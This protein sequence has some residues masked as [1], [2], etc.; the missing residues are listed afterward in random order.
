MPRRPFRLLVITRDLLPLRRHYEDVFAALGEAGVAISIR[1]TH[2]AGLG[3]SEYER[4]LRARN[5]SA[6]V[7]Q[8]PR[9][10]GDHYRLAVNLRQLSNLLRFSH[11]DFR[12]RDWVRDIKWDR[13]A[14]GPLRWA[15]RIER[16]GSRAALATIALAERVDRLLPASEDAA[17]LIEAESPDAVAAV[18]VMRAP[19]F[20]E[21][22]KA[23]RAAGVPTAIWV[24]SWDNLSSKGLLHFVPDR[25]FVWNATQLG[26]LERYHGIPADRVSI[27]GAQSFDHWFNGDRP[28]GREDFC[29]RHGLDPDRPI[30]LY[31]VSS[32]G[33]EPS[34]ATFLLRWLEAIRASDD[35]QLA[36]ASVIVRPH[37]T[38]PDPWLEATTDD[39]R[40]V[41]SPNASADPDGSPGFRRRFREELHHSSVA[42]GINTS[43]LI[44]AA[45]FGKPALTVEL[46]ELA[47]TQRGTVHFDYLNT[48]GG[49][50][51]RSATS[52]E[53]HVQGLASLIHRDPY[54]RD[55]HGERFIAE[56]VRPQGDVPSWRVFT[57]EMLR[58]LE[59]PSTVR[60]P[61]RAGRLA[62]A[63]LV[64]WAGVLGAPLEPDGFTRVRNRWSKAWSRRRHRTRKRLRLLK[65]RTAT[66]WARG[67][68]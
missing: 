50:V 47:L 56:F 55:E 67:R 58:L 54:A 13:A 1:Y 20:V 6:D 44:D 15:S 59:A 25:V 60:E 33:V 45:I 61:G 68:S 38:A 4:T 42:F 26:E 48:V 66:V 23:A 19:E 46:P 31:L 35:P 14:P 36:G 34:P 27:T 64:R 57:D 7:A 40:V 22:L 30:V 24:Q 39:P 11:P 10:R 32:R 49:G 17:A 53:E 8:L 16:L 41:I 65:R 18:G 3:V 2:D 43:A 12:G 28:A 37:P 9:G 63:L 29:R 62:G 21:H 52:L 51:L 5:C